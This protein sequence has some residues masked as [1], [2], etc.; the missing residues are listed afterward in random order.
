MQQSSSSSTERRG[1]NS[2]HASSLSSD[3]GS[4]EVLQYIRSTVH[5]KKNIRGG[6]L[7]GLNAPEIVEEPHQSNLFL[8][9]NDNTTT[10][11]P[12]LSDDTSTSSSSS[13]ILNDD[14]KATN[15]ILLTV[16]CFLIM[17]P[18]VLAGV[19]QCIYWIKKKKLD[20]VERQ[21]EVVSTNPRSRMLV[22]SEIF[23]ND[24]RVSFFFDVWYHITCCLYICLLLY[25][26][27]E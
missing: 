6:N 24:I 5:L 17:A 3:G 11:L 27:L 10:T 1:M 13:S 19:A 16:M 14:T 12:P 7:R 18:C 15:G 21:L 20:R 22:L 4:D 9:N 25:N 23:K 8:N 2:V 26:L